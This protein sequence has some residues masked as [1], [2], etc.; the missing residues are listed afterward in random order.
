[1]RAARP[2]ALHRDARTPTTGA[3]H[4]LPA[5]PAR[6][7]A[8]CLL[9]RARAMPCPCAARVLR[10]PCELSRAVR[11]CGDPGGTPLVKGFG[12]SQPLPGARTRPARRR[13]GPRGS[14]PAAAARSWTGAS[15]RG[16][17]APTPQ[18]LSGGP[19][20]WAPSNN[21]FTVS[22]GG[23][24]S[25][26]GEPLRSACG[27]CFRLGFEQPS[28]PSARLRTC[29]VGP[30]DPGNQWAIRLPGLPKRTWVLCR[31]TKAAVCCAAPV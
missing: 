9:A 5:Q 19:L 8:A 13:A 25:P 27:L 30:G 23:R 18:E 3:A 15:H 11:F 4:M 16:S 2:T 17:S 7:H 14:A 26:D 24:R 31:R 22:P 21:R 12:P 29:P 6:Q 28:V 1:M 10:H 20:C